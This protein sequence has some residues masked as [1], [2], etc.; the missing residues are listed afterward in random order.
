M[1]EVVALECTCASALTVRDGGMAVVIPRNDVNIKTE[2]SLARQP[3]RRFSH[4]M[5]GMAY[6]TRE[7]RVDVNRV[8]AKAGIGKDVRKVVTLRAEGVGPIGGRIQN[9]R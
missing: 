4:S 6:R 7:T 3:H 5:G 9:D 8:L 1:V 2:Q